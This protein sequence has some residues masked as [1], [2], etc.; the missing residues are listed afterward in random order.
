VTETKF[1][2]AITTFR[3]PDMVVAAVRSCLRQGGQLNSVVVVDDASGD[4][5]GKRIAALSDAR[6]VFHERAANGGIGAARRDALALCSSEW[7]VMLDSDHELLPGA[8]DR[9]ASHIT[10]LGPE[11]GIVGARYQWD[12]GLATPVRLPDQTIDYQGRIEWAS[13]PDSI[14]TDY[15]CCISRNVRENVTWSTERSG[16]VDRLF[17]LDAARVAQASFLPDCLALQRSD[18]A[19]SHS[20]GDPQYLLAC[21]LREATGAVAVC[22]QILRTHG[23]ALRRWGLPQL[24]VTYK[25][26]I[27]SAA[28]AGQ[29][30]LALRWAC[31][32][33]L[34]CGPRLIGLRVVLGGIIGGRLFR[35]AYLGILR[36]RQ[37]CPPVVT[38]AESEGKDSDTN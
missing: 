16:A 5:T 2:V 13:L 24:A 21:R 9:L 6:I 8:L 31:A 1:D 36:R 35:W 38:V 18:G 22:G 25:M 28:L 14:G 27:L 26:G 19:F 34:S 32:G 37:S 12:T 3:R 17:H 10:S 23:E 4:D 7:T 30:A 11:V 20:R 29:R 33:L 15:L